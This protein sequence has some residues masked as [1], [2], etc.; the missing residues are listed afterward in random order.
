M[1]YLDQLPPDTLREIIKLLDKDDYLR[2]VQIPEII[3]EYPH[4]HT[5]QIEELWTPQEGI[6]YHNVYNISTGGDFRGGKFNTTR[7]CHDGN[8]A[9]ICIR[10][11]KYKNDK[12]IILRRAT[13][14]SKLIDEGHKIISTIEIDKH[15]YLTGSN[16]NMKYSTEKLV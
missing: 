10:T 8:L 12:L 14:I 3:K 9:D 5:K 4:D 7:F 15:N 6:T 2:F 13:I 11:F 1:T 16:Y